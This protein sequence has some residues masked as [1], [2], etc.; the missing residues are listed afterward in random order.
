MSVTPTKVFSIIWPT[1]PLITNHLSDQS[2]N[3][4]YLSV[5]HCTKHQISEINHHVANFLS[6]TGQL[7]FVQTFYIPCS[8]YVHFRISSN[9]NLYW[10]IEQK[11][12]IPVSDFPVNI[13][14]NNVNEHNEVII[15]FW[16]TFNGEDK[17][18][19]IIQWDAGVGTYHRHWVELTLLWFDRI[20]NFSWNSSNHSILQTS[21][22]NP[23]NPATFYC[24]KV[25][26]ILYLK[27]QLFVGIISFI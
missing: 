11:V 18:N 25:K 9:I 10:E 22:R 16:V 26:H 8:I 5:G 19:I 12:K 24:Q 7:L 1:W 13:E 14:D 6:S 27:I 4:F 15:Q 2:C 21:K 17:A 3:S 23:I 20:L